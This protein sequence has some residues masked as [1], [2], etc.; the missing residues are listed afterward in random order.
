LLA[1]N[2]SVVYASKQTSI[3]MNCIE[4]AL[5]KRALFVCF[6]DI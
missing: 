2:R 1:V 3:I 6:D 5:V 4:H